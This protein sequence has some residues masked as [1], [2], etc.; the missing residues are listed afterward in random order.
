[1]SISSIQNELN[2]VDRDIAAAEKKKAEA[3]KK[4]SEYETR[5]QGVRKTIT[6]N[7]TASSLSSKM[8]QIEGYER[9]KARRLDESA[10]L[11]KKIAAL[12]EKR[13]GI[14]KRLQKAEEDERKAQETKT[15]KMQQ[16]YEQR[17]RELTS[18]SASIPTLPITTG[19]LP[20]DVSSEPEYD[21]FISHAWEDKDSFVDAFVAA[22]EA[23]GIRPWYDRQRITWGDSMRAKID[24][25]L[26]H[27]KFGIVVISP[28]YIAEGK[29][30]TK[31]ELDGLFQLESVNG[32][33]ILPIWHNISKQ[34]VMSFS[35]IVAGRLAMQADS[36]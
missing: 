3:D 12:R 13:L 25:G 21:V 26:R 16:L 34:Q 31:A 30:W 15:K 33:M 9:D 2:A 19:A 8:R 27:S 7:T 11:G 28:N 18:S 14:A 32:K 6:K 10:D 20:T 24:E 1:M 17:I 5:I 4:A 23:L 29:Y 36:L 35:S 22:L